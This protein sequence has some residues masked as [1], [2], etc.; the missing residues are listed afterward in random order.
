MLYNFYSAEL[1]LF[2]SFSLQMMWAAD[3]DESVASNVGSRL[4]PLVVQLPWDSGAESKRES[5]ENGNGHS[6]G[7]LQSK[8]GNTEGSDADEVAIRSVSAYP[9]CVLT[10]NFWS[11]N[12]N[13][14]ICAVVSSTRNA[15]DE[16]PV[17]CVAAILIMNRHKIIRET[18]SVDDLIKVGALF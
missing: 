14:Q 18:R 11:K 6:K 12:D 1:T 4:A 17:F 15:N 5:M 8:H 16:L 3:F 9:L 2:K 7:G 13:M 10:K